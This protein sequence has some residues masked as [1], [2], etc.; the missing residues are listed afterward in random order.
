MGVESSDAQREGA[1]LHLNRGNPRESSLRMESVSTHA[2]DETSLVNSTC[3]R[4]IRFAESLESRRGNDLDLRILD[5]A[6]SHTY[7]I[8]YLTYNTSAGDS[9]RVL[10]LVA[11]IRICTRLL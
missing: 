6:S 7:Q 1:V 8:F 2:V 11:S 9:H 10:D 5:L 3:Q 4:S